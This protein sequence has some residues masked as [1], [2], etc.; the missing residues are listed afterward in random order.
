MQ[1]TAIGTDGSR[2]ITEPNGVQQSLQQG[3]DDGFGMQAPVGQNMSMMTPNGL[4][5]TVTWVQALRRSPLLAVAW[6]GGLD[7]RSR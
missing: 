7:G 6:T 4:T 2:T 3:P 1:T 5:A